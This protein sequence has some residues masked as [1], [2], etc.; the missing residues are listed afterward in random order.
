[1]LD[2]ARVRSAELATEG[3]ARRW[4]AVVALWLGRGLYPIMVGDR[5]DAC[6]PFLARLADVE[7]W[8]LL[9]VKSKRVFSRPAPGRLPGQVGTK[10]KDGDRFPCTDDRSHGELDETWEGLDAKGAR[11]QVRCEKYMYLRTA[12]RVEVSLLQIIRHGASGT[13][14]DPTIRWC[15]WKSDR[16]APLAEISVV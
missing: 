1:V 13:A 3:A 10:R 2:T 16:S 9:R 7:L 5:W 14:R 6:A 15:V 4:R 11:V 8:S 12:R